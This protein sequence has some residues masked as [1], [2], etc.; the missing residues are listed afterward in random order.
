MTVRR[1][2][3]STNDFQVTGVNT[4]AGS[5]NA[6]ANN[7]TLCQPQDILNSMYVDDFLWRA[8]NSAI[9]VA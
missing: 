6:Y 7:I 9:A 1:E 2:N 8:D 5:S 4:Q 3:S